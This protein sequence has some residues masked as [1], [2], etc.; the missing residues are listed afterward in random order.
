MRSTLASMPR[1]VALG[2]SVG[3]FGGFTTFSSF[4]WDVVEH[5]ESDRWPAAVAMLLGTIVLGLLAMVA[6]LAAGRA[7]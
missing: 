3:V 1:P 2:I 4:M 5:A 7:A 6:G